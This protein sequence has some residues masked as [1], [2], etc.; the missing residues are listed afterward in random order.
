MMPPVL[1]AT[2]SRA[3]CT[4]RAAGPAPQLGD[5]LG[6]LGEPGGAQRVA[7]G[8]Q[9]AARVHARRRR[10]R[11]SVSP[12]TVAGPAAPG[13]EEAERLEGVELLGAGGVVQLDHVD[14]GRAEAEV[15]PGRRRSSQPVVVVELAVA[16]AQDAGP[17]PGRAAGRGRRAGQDGRGGAVGERQHMSRVSAPATTGEAEDLVDGDGVLELGQRVARPRSGGPWPPRR[18]SARPWCPGPRICWRTHGR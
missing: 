2:P 17:D 18:R 1:T 10:R 12:A 3:P 11:R 16:R 15:L 14:V 13:R 8:H 6:D 7:P 5:Q 9:A 4:W